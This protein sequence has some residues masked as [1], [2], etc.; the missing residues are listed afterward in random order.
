M[1]NAQ[2]T[3]ESPVI[4]CTPYSS[5]S[6]CVGVGVCLSNQIGTVFGKGER[7]PQTKGIAAGGQVHSG[8]L[9]AILRC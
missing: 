4:M 7:V 3:I 1:Q 2:A 5:P 6:R 8:E 9:G